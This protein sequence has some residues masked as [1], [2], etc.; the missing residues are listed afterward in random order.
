MPINFLP[1]DPQ[2]DRATAPAL[3]VQPKRKN[4]PS[5]RSGFTFAHRSTER[6]AAPGTPQFLYWQCREAAIAA[7]EA[8]EASAG[9]HKRWQGNRKKIRLF[10]DA[11]EDLNAYYD[12]D[13][14]SFFHQAVGA[15]TLFSG[16]STDVVAHE[17]GHG[18]LDSIRSDL[19]SVNFLEV[20]AFHEAF[21]DCLAIL[22]A[23]RDQPS[24]QNLLQAAPNLRKRNFIETTAE[25]LSDGIRR[26]IPNHNAAEPRHAF[27]RFN[28]QLPSTLPGDGGPGTLINEVHSFGMVFTGCFWD[29][30]ANLFAASPTQNEVSL[31]TAAATAGR[32]L[33]EGARTAMVTPRYFQSVGRAMVLADQSLNAGANR[34]AIRQAFQQHNLLVGTSAAVTPS[35]ALEGGA[36]SGAGAAI[37]S[38]TRRDLARR[39]GGAADAKLSFKAINLGGTRM[40][41][42]VQTRQV[43]LGAVDKRLKNVFA[44]AHEVVTIGSSGARAAVMGVLPNSSDTELEI[45]AFVETLLEHDR[46]EFG[47][48]S[49]GT[50]GI[51]ASRRQL[52]RCTH[53]IESVAGKKMLQRMRF[54]CACCSLPF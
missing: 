5:T 29:L 32:I 11:G 25:E 24:R 41:H 37:S 30:I 1:N 10:Q 47:K 9:V 40:L 15:K 46:I 22:T 4:R 49:K 2:A 19:W 43:N 8:W 12:R 34:E 45:R 7:L 27:N 16:A 23:L 54:H 18:L 53:R 14:V 51:L 31:Q 17:V 33:I 3:R 13:S 39:L 28:F 44:V 36:P 38:K 35:M 6:I 26:L 20:G 48:T 21:G 50:K 52:P 42:A